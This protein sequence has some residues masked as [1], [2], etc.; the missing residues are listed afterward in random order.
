[1]QHDKRPCWL[2]WMLYLFTGLLACVGAGLKADSPEPLTVATWGGA[3]EAVLEE[4]IFQ[5]FT[6]ATGVPVETQ[7]Y[8]GGL[9]ILE[10]DPP[11]LVDMTMNHA[12]AACS[13]GLLRPLD[14]GDLPPGANGTP[15]SRDFIPGSRH[16][17]ALTHTLYATV[18]AYDTRAFPGVRPSEV[19]DLFD[20]DRFPGPRA[21]QSIPDGNLEWALLS[22]GVPR[23]E[24]YDLLSTPRGQDLAFARLDSL[25]DQIRW[26]RDGDEPVRMLEAGEVVM[27]TGYN[28]R[29]FNARLDRDSPV[30]IIW[31]GQ[32]QENQTWTIPRTTDRPELAW[33]FI[34]FATTTERLT[35]VAERIAYGPA[36]HSASQRVGR[37]PDGLDMRAH[38]PTHP[39]NAASAVT[40]DVAWYAQVH[41]RIGDRFD[42]WQRSLDTS[43]P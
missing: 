40:K 32:I 11:D 37:H 26:W 9:D 2:T 4:V 21:L 34:Q 1:M 42:Q 13:A 38:I 33:A 7:A 31:D 18:I 28:G 14:L 19:A 20:L 35:A 29:F 23:Q 25:S 5:P 6:E 24:L 30:E 12:M 16:P 36:R 10:T 8:S 17:C 27:A 39:Y 22:Y 15:A 43:A 3:Y 41:D